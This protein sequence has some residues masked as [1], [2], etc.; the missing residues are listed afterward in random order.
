MSGYNVKRIKRQNDDCGNDITADRRQAVRRH[1]GK[2]RFHGLGGRGSHEPLPQQDLRQ[3]SGHNARQGDGHL[4][5]AVLPD[6]G[7]QAFRGQDERHCGL[8]GCL[9]R[10]VG[11][12]VYPRDRTLHEI[13]IINEL[14]L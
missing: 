1:D 13:L 9:L 8:R 7:K 11:G 6:D 3:P 5:D 10:Y 14:K 4:S 12:D 2:P